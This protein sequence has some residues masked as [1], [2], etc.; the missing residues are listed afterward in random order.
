MSRR[1]GD[2]LEQAVE[3]ILGMTIGGRRV[4][5]VL[6]EQGIAVAREFYLAVTLDRSARQPVLLFSTLGG[7]DIEQVAREE[8]AALRR[9]HIDP[10]IGLQE[11]QLRDLGYWAGFSADERSAFA[12]IVRAVWRLYQEKDATLVEVN[13]LCR[14]APGGAVGGTGGTT[15]AGGAVGGTGDAEAGHAP[16]RLFI[17]LDAKVTIDDNALFRHQELRSL[18]GFSPQQVVDD[19]RELRARKAGVAY[20]GLDGD[21]GI[22]GN[23][24]G[25]V[26]SVLDQVATAGGRPANF[27][28][29][30]G[31]ARQDVI[32]AALEVILSDPNVRVLLVAIFG[33]I[34]RCDEVAR[35]LLAAVQTR[36]RGGSSAP[37]PVVV[38]LTGTRADEG[39]AILVAAGR[40]DVCAMGTL[41]D[42]VAK[43]VELARGIESTR[44]L[45]PNPAAE[46]AT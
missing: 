22:L 28:D 8:P 46:P 3:A 40:Q 6:L 30:G 2:E 37:L 43:A 20:V 45:D 13:P 1:D 38:R 16:A 10:L 34:T 41:N 26:M 11:F 9:L 17:A 23:G 4:E 33:G 5:S 7:V 21:I 27:L 18:R 19:P 35:G 32:A 14:Q 31:G 15:S 39:S 29:V 12:E 42:A 25:M 44:R 24:A 36:E